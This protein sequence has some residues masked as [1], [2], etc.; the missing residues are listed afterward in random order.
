MSHVKERTLVDKLKGSS[1][2]RGFA[3]N[4]LR[5]TMAGQKLFLYEEELP[6]VINVSFNEK[7]CMYRCKMCPYDAPV[8][9]DMYMQGAEMSFET[10]KN[11][12]AS[13]PNQTKFSFDISAI[14]ETLAFKRLPEFIAYMKRERPRVNTIVSTNGLLLNEDTARA[15]IESGLDSLQISLF[16]ADAH[17]HEFITG[18]KSFDRVCA[19]IKTAW[20]VRAKMK[21]RKPYMQTFMMECVETKGKIDEFVQ[22]WSQ[23]VDEAFSRP[24]YNLGRDIAGMTPTFRKTAEAQR[25]PCIMPWYS[26]AIRSTGDVLA[27]YMFHW[28][29]ETKEHRIGNINEQSLREIWGGGA[30]KAF[31]E[32]HLSMRLDDYPVC[33]KCDLW[34]AYTNIW[35]NDGGEGP[36]YSRVRVSDFFKTAPDHRGG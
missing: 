22:H 36:R 4:F 21:S 30:F 35:K 10:L 7:T 25:Y 14:G 27:C 1:S 5:H 17:D 26:T 9:R 28:H 20:R 16:G 31:R 15:L 18:S 2:L 11:L 32:A 6:R 8:V 23:Y 3:S 33:Q 19:N 34:D 29:S 24:I 12:V 13:I